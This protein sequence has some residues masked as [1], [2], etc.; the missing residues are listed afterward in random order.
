MIHHKAE[1]SELALNEARA[2]KGLTVAIH[3]RSDSY[4]TVDSV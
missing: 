2:R 4:A 1:G 3:R